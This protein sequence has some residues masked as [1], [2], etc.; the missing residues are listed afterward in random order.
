MAWK[1]SL[2]DLSLIIIFWWIQVVIKCTVS[3]EPQNSTSPVTHGKMP[4]VFGCL[5]CRC[6]REHDGFRESSVF[7]DCDQHVCHRFVLWCILIR[8]TACNNFSMC[9]S[10]LYQTKFCF[11]CRFELKLCRTWTIRSCYVAGQHV[12]KTESLSPS[13]LTTCINFYC[14]FLHQHLEHIL[15][16]VFIL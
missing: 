16:N 3:T 2:A 13:L 9:A 5:N 14:P 8:V 10:N 6:I 15:L 12:G 4:Q 7:L 11:S 1:D